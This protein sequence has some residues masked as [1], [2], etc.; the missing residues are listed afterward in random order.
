MSPHAVESFHRLMPACNEGCCM[1]QPPVCEKRAARGVG[2]S[3]LPTGTRLPR[4]A[5][6]ESVSNVILKKAQVGGI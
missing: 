1:L 2:H 5:S 6:P 4:C 3:L